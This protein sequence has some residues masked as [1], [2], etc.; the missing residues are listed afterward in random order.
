M[1]CVERNN[2][3]T[4]EKYIANNEQP[5]AEGDHGKVVAKRLLTGL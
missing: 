2:I 5:Q 3:G 1:S 4:V